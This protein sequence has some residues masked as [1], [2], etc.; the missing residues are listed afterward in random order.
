MGTPKL[1]GWGEYPKWTFPL[2]QVGA[3]IGIKTLP[4]LVPGILVCGAKQ[5]I[6]GFLSHH[7]D[8]GVT[9]LNIISTGHSF[10]T[11]EDPHFFLK[12]KQTTLLP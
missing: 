2:L 6:R 3:G 9:Y 11:W 8:K 4:F 5:I 1:R 12:D 10:L 7:I